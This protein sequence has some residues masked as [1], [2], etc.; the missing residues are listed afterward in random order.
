MSN[1]LSAA[2]G[3][4]AGSLEVVDHQRLSGQAYTF[5]ASLP[6]ILA[7]TA[8]EALKLLEV[9][10][11][12]IINRLHENAKLMY[13]LLSQLHPKMIIKSAS[14]LSPIFHL[15]LPLGSNEE[16]EKI[17]QDIVDSVSC[18][19]MILMFRYSKKEF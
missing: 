10:E 2:G 4:C 3:F 17:L 15:S 1:A 14:D 5:S 6:A 8:L 7:V 19:R 13:S 12:Q 11:D 18:F 9:D 16:S